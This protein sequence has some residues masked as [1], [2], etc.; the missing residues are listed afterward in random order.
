MEIENI[1]HYPPSGVTFTWYIN[2]S[3]NSVLILPEGQNIIGYSHISQTIYGSD[4]ILRYL[5]N[6]PLRLVSTYSLPQLLN[7]YENITSYF[8]LILNIPPPLIDELFD[9]VILLFPINRL[10]NR[11]VFTYRIYHSSQFPT[12]LHLLGAIEG[13][14]NTEANQEDIGRILSDINIDQQLR[15]RAL[16]PNLTYKTIFE[17]L[18]GKNIG[19]MGINSIPDI[20]GFYTVKTLLIF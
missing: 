8:N 16:G 12:Y 9:K 17:E 7:N 11:E 10:P 19:I 3:D 2:D 1:I 18:T 4:N 20:P 13:F 14:Y 6:N 15:L 5:S